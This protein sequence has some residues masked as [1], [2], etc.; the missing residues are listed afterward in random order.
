MKE[1]AEAQRQL[2]SAA[3]ARA[4]VLEN[5]V[6]EL[7]ITNKTLMAETQDLK[8]TITAMKSTA[9]KNTLL[10]DT[11]QLQLANQYDLI[12][13]QGNSVPRKASTDSALP[14]VENI[15]IILFLM[16]SIIFS[17]NSY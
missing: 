2:A 14:K 17:I 8:D 5:K 10:I 3:E 15:L 6:Q 16:Y 4:K 11:L 9:T 1:E 13:Q 7:E 12:Q